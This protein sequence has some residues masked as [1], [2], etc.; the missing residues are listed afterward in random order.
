M[1]AANSKN[2]ITESPAS[3]RAE[4]TPPHPLRALSLFQLAVIAVVTTAMGCSGNGI[5]T[6]PVEGIVV[7]EDGTPVQTGTVEFNSLEKDLTARG[8]IQSDGT[9]RL[10]TFTD[11]DG[12]VAGIHDA[13]VVQLVSTEDLPLHE[14]DH[15]PTIDPKYAHYDSAGL[16]FTVRSDRT[17]SIRIVV[18]PVTS[19]RT[20]TPET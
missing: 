17:N 16:Q 5:P 9:F 1:H 20:S 11:G 13:V 14:H 19:G 6:C 4:I 8:S 10:T 3:M 18:T 12:A 15:G 2:V 7:L